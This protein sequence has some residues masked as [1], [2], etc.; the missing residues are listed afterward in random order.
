MK[1]G[2]AGANQTFDFL[3]VGVLVAHHQRGRVAVQGVR[4]IRVQ[5][6]LRQEHLED[7]HEV[8]ITR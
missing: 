3:V 4:G 7:V 6:E 5:E 8:C 1:L 2:G